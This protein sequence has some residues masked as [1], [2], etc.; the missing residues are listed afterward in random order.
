MAA[1]LIPVLIRFPPLLLDQIDEAAGD[2]P[3]AVFLRKLIERA[4]RSDGPSEIEAP[5]DPA[6][7]RASLVRTPSPNL[8]AQI[9]E[10]EGHKL[11]PQRPAYGAL[12]SKG[13]KKP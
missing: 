10:A 1:D 4:L 2:V 13:A 12:L 3:R 7:A 11:R 8:I 9:N 5:A 6:P